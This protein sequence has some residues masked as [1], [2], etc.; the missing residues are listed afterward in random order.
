MSDSNTVEENVTAAS[1]DFDALVNQAIGA[2]Q[3]RFVANQAEDEDVAE[4]EAATPDVADA[5]DRAA[6]EPDGLKRL[7]DREAALVAKE[8]DYEAR[9]NDLKRQ[10]QPDPDK[11]SLT[12]LR[13]LAETNVPG[14]FSKLGL[15]QD[16]VMD[17]LIAEKLGDKA[18]PVLKEKL[19]DYKLKKEIEAI[20]SERDSE[21]AASNAREF[22]QKISGDAREYV[23][24]SLDVK[25]AP[26]VS[27]VAKADTDFVHSLVLR[28]IDSDARAKVARGET[29]GQLLTYAEA[30]ANI[31]TLFSKVAAVVKKGAADTVSKKAVG[32]ATSNPNIPVTRPKNDK[33]RDEIAELEALG[34]KAGMA[35]YNKSQSA[36]RR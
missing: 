22:Y 7:T 34:L 16:Y 30:V 14:V 31:E 6:E 5:V 29:D 21:R 28:E 4:V 19:R 10:S 12:D 26:T 36:G 18:P 2:V 20:R 27:E 17:V 9:L 35:A 24:K 15:D 11:L 8:K 25:V 23:S 33:P 1:D 32:T 3:P 13:K